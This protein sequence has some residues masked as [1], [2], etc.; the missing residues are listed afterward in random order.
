MA[1]QWL[2]TT[3]SRDDAF[4]AYV[5]TSTCQAASKAVWWAHYCVVL[6]NSYLVAGPQF[7]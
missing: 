6:L 5:L 3:L 4:G 7:Q 1:K 2:C